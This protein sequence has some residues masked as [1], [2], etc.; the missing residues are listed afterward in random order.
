MRVIADLHI[1]GRFSRATSEQMSIS[2]IAKY[3]QIK[4]LTLVGTGDFTHPEWLKE[5]QGAT[6]PDADTG[7]LKLAASDSPVRFM[8]QTEV[9]TIFDY[10]GESKKVHHV[11]L[12][13]SIETATQINE[14][15]Q[16]FGSLSADGRPILDVSAPQLVEEVMEASGDNMV[17]PAHVWTPWFS[18]FGAFSGFD[19]V[20][21]C[22]QDMAKHIHALETGLSSD[23]PMNWRLSKLDR[24]ALLSNSDCHSFWPW[25]IGREA[26]VFDLENFSYK[27][28]IDAIAANDPARFRFTIETDPAYGK[29]HWTGHRNC[30]ISMSPQEAIKFGNVCPVCRRK[31]TKGVEQ[32]VEELADRPSDYKREVAPGF[33]RL[34]PLSEVIAA[35]LGTETPSTQAVWKNYNL[36]TARFGNEYS[37]LIDAPLD[38]MAQV[39]DPAVAKAV[40]NVREGTAKVT[41]GYDGVYGQLVLGI[42][43]QK[44]KP[45]PPAP[46]KVQ[47]RSMSDFW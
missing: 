9:C 5:I 40:V 45:K 41:P 11:I 33:L 22:Y 15:L 28:V 35:V 17:F 26:N 24:Y 13:P 2:E 37:V 7:L 6:T 36:L 27:A 3:A 14:R 21:D 38:A 29:Y 16:N 43:A 10:K 19:T 25:R 20:E 23:P 42:E 4:G 44:A 32:R 12:T 30:K 8:L 39:V 34:L 18:I 47:Q 46:P 1:H 31:L